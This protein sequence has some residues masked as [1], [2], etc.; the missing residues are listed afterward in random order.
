MVDGI[1]IKDIAIIKLIGFILKAHP[2]SN[3]KK[4]NLTI[5][6]KYSSQII[7]IYQLHQELI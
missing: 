4:E 1:L 2:K 6:N 5:I 3:H 7:F